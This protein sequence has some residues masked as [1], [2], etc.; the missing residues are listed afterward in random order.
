MKYGIVLDRLFLNHA[1]PA[2]HPERP[3]R[4]EALLEKLEPLRQHQ[5]VCWVTPKA[6][7]ENDLLDVHS[8]EHVERIRATAGQPRLAL[9]PDTYTGPDSYQ[10]ALMAAGSG[11]ELVAMLAEG[12]LDGGFVIGRPPGHHAERNRAMGFCLFN[13]VAVA[14][15]AAVSRGWAKRV[16]I[17]DFDV[18]HGNGTQD[19]FYNRADVL[20]VSSH[21]Y[22]F[23]PGTGR[24]DEVGSGKGEG[25][26]VNL[27]LRAGRGD[28]FFSKLYEKLVA[29]IL[30]E[31]EPDLILVSAGFDAHQDDPLGG[32]EVSAEGFVRLTQLLND[33]SRKTGGGKILYLLEGGYSLHGLTQSVLRSIEATLHERQ[34]EIKVAQEPETR[35]YIE[36]A[37]QSFSR[38]WK[39]LRSV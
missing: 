3:E 32:M 18:H 1:V 27:P 38:F 31:F 33:L 12:R 19:I 21:Q 13:N 30:L 26:T 36:S 28:F 17:V 25:F 15:Q 20:Y 35:E 29:P 7:I 22:P 14:A 5:D 9:D 37:R 16:A 4:I 23:Y 10:T 11:I 2:G 39:S 8:A 34:V 24:Q 6:A